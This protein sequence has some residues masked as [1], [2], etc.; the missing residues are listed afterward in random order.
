MRNTRRARAF[1]VISGISAGKE[2][3]VDKK[4]V[5]STNIIRFDPAK[6]LAQN[7]RENPEF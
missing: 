7:M 6:L 4:Q 3:D 1:A 5:T 2:V